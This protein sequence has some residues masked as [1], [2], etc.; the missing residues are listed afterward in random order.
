[1]KNKFFYIIGVAFCLVTMFIVRTFFFHST[2]YKNSD[3]L[4]Q[5][6]W[7]HDNVS[8]FFTTKENGIISMDDDGGLLFNYL[9]K[10]DSIMIVL[11]E[12]PYDTLMNVKILSITD[13]K[14]MVE[15]NNEQL[16]WIREKE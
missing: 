5:K 12:K 16:T 3:F 10:G 14:F 2:S 8:L 11:N 15:E 13:E 6:S 9:I 1:M 4:I 7:G